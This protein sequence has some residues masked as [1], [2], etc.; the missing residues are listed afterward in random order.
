MSPLPNQRL[1]LASATK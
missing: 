1:K